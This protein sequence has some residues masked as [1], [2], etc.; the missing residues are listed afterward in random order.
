[1]FSLL[2]LVLHLRNKCASFERRIGGSLEFTEDNEREASVSVPYAWTVPLMFNGLDVDES[3]GYQSREA[4]VGIV[5]G[6]SS[7]DHG[8]SGS[9]KKAAAVAS[10]FNPLIAELEDAIL[11]W[12]PTTFHLDGFPTF[13]RFTPIAVKPTDARAWGLLEYSFPY[14]FVHPAYRGKAALKEEAFKAEHP[15]LGA[16]S[17][18][19]IMVKYAAPEDELEHASDGPFTFFVPLPPATPEQL[20]A[21]DAASGTMD[22]TKAVQSII[23]GIRD[24]D[25]AAQE[26]VHEEP[27]PLDVE[28]EFTNRGVEITQQ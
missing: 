22:V 6:I 18:T 2:E 3:A 11:R 8:K 1:M 9:A 13:M 14:K 24:P 27:V 7:A 23:A 12:E 28:R 20:A 21:F 17:I 25:T 26:V 15:N 4:M 16:A 5:I 10:G 19:K